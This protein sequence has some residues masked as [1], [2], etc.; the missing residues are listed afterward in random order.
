MNLALVALI[1]IHAFLPS[2]AAT[3]THSPLTLQLKV[4]PSGA[5]RS[6]RLRAPVTVGT[7]PFRDRFH[8]LLA[9]PPPDPA[10]SQPRVLLPPFAGRYSDLRELD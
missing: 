8:L 2:C 3:G 10:D 5:H 6:L 7:V 9:P 1:K 4:D